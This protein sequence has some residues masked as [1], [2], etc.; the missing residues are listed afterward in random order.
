MVRILIAMGTVVL[1][2]ILPSHVN[3]AGDEIV[4]TVAVEPASL[5]PGDTVTITVLAENAGQKTIE[6]GRGS[7][8]CRLSAVVRIDDMDYAVYAPRACLKDLVPWT[9]APGES[10]TESWPWAGALAAV[11]TMYLLPPGTYEL[12]GAAGPFLSAGT[13]IEIDD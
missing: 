9:L 2:L 10:R 11:D 7:S 8:S 1:P 13:A 3:G 4:V 6:F 12:L 5:A